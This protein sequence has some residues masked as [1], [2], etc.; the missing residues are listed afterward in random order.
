MNATDPP[1]DAELI[2]RHNGTRIG[3]LRDDYD[4]LSRSLE[5]R[6]GPGLLFDLENVQVLEGPQGTLFGRNAVGG[7][8][9]LQ[10]ALPTND[11]GGHVQLA[12]G[13][14][15]DRELDGALNIP[16]LNDVLLARVAFNGQLRDG[17][18]HVLAE[19]GHPNGVDADNR[20]Y[21]SVRGTITFRPTHWFQNDTI[22]TYQKFDSNGSP[23]IVTNLDPSGLLPTLYPS[24]I[25][26]FAQQQTLG[27]RT[28]F[29]IDTRDES[30]GNL[31]MINNVT[32]VELNDSLTF[33]NVFG[34]D[35]ATSVFALDQDGTALP[36]LNFPYLPSTNY[37]TQYTDEAQLLGKS[38]GGR[39]DW[40]VGAFLS[41]Q[42]TPKDF[43]NQEGVFFGGTPIGFAASADNKQEIRSKALFAQ[44]T[45]DLSALVSGLKLTTGLRYTWDNSTYTSNP[46]AI[47]AV[48][49]PMPALGFPTVMNCGP[50]T[51]VREKS[52]ALTWTVG[53][54][55]SLTE[56]TLLYITSRRG[57]GAGGVNNYNQPSFGSEFVTDV[58]AGVKSDWKVGSALVRTNANIFYQD[59]SDIQVPERVSLKNI[60]TI[61]TQ[62][63]GRAAIS[64]AKFQVTARLTSRFEA[65]AQF[66]Y[67]NYRYTSFDSGVSA[68]TIEQLDATRTLNRP[69]F[70]YGLNASYRIP[71]DAHVGDV[72]ARATW[73]WQSS[74]GDT[75]Q[76]G[77]LIDAYGLLNANLEWKGIFGTQIDG[78]LFATNL[79]NRI[80]A[81]GIL[82]SEGLGITNTIYGEPRMYG[83]RVN[84]RFGATN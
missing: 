26:S 68:A 9:L 75:S 12:Y 83:V 69:R 41:D 28:V 42:P 37:S 77:G 43:W 62:N 29:P 48:C 18:T 30:S 39:W 32:S 80:Y 52:S 8:V 73:S 21:W 33:R 4:A 70:K 49:A 13:N 47:G 82:P 6:G 3:A 22:V 53:L 14:Y 10:S 40:I 2:A 46:G 63:A 44:D 78:S 45:Y 84:Y 66:A 65:G 25:S 56:D 1:L 67:L 64:G 51:T 16:I 76:Q 72:I 36:A 79:A 55:Y 50:F 74:S 23:Y 38:F 61:I 24:L 81:A 11:F 20:D 7:A 58:E 5:R 34:Y 71:L 35:Q 57:Y 59:F 17:F 60:E 19:P 54:D 27:I 31:L 15:N